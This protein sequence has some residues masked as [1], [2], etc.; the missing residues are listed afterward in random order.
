MERVRA[1][2]GVVG[3][4]RHEANNALATVLKTILGTKTSRPLPTGAGLPVK[5]GRV[6]CGATCD[7]RLLRSLWLGRAADGHSNAV[8][9]TSYLAYR[10][11]ILGHA[12]RSN[13]SPA[14]SSKDE[15][16]RLTF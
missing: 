3:R 16:D 7:D 4:Q 2:H 15:I 1:Q 11:S 8:T 5:E 13:L 6:G 10:P 14:R 9:W 12:T